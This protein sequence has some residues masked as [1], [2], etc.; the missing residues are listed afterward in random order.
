MKCIDQ[1]KL[2]SKENVHDLS[3]DPTEKEMNDVFKAV[4][5]TIKDGKKKNPPVKYVVIV[6]LAGHGLVKS[7][8]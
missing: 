2:V 5:K 8:T 4:S 6:L 1:Y 7:A 3:N